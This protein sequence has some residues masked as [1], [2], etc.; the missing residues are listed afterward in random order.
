MSDTQEG[1]GTGAAVERVGAYRLAL[2]LSETAWEDGTR[3]AAEPLLAQIGP[4]LV[5]AVGSIAANIAEGY[6]RL[7]RRDRIRF[8]EYALGSAEEAR[9][10]YVVARRAL[11]SADYE[12]RLAKLTSIRRLLLTMIRNERSGE[13]WKAPAPRAP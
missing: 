2:E 3:I 9:S 7:S 10:W 1:A 13:G 5:R 12:A 4:Q 8:Y 11:P 6:A